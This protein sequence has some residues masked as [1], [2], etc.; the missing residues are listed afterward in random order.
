MYFRR[1]CTYAAGPNA[2]ILAG[3]KLFAERGPDV[4]MRDI[5]REAGHQNKSAVQYHFRDLNGLVTAIVEERLIA[6]EEYGVPAFRVVN[7]EDSSALIE[8][9]VDSLLYAASRQGS[10]H[11]MR[12]LETMRIYI[13][14]WN[15]TAAASWSLATEELVKLA[16]GSTEILRRQRVSAL[17]TAMFALLADYERNTESSAPAQIV[18]MLAALFDAPSGIAKPSR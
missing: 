7:V 3:E 18:T 10:T 16:P 12:F 5:A 11:Y 9:L 13:K 17:A 14:D 6:V 2:L 1:V 4:P 15:S 8:F